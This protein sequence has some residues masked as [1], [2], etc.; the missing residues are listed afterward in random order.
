MK[1]QISITEK[2]P[3]KEILF[4]TEKSITPNSFGVD[5]SISYFTAHEISRFFSVP[6]AN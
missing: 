3:F 2:F 4:K 1:T 5:A 6:L